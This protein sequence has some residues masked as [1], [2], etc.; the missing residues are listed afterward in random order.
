MSMSTSYTADGN[1]SSTYTPS[2]SS[3]S[4]MEIVGTTLRISDTRTPSSSSDNGTAGEICWDSN[5]LYVCVGT[6]T[7]K[8]C[9]LGNLLW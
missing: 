4:F 8:R 5:Y 7:W 9:T 1:F 3:V 6:N 2:D